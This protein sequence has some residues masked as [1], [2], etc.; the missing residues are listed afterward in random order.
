MVTHWNVK[1]NVKLVLWTLVGLASCSCRTLTIA[2]NS[3]RAAFCGAGCS[4]V[5]STPAFCGQSTPSMRRHMYASV[6]WNQNRGFLGSRKSS[7]SSGTEIQMSASSDTKDMKDVGES[8]SESKS[9]SKSKSTPITLLAGF[10]GAGKTST[11][12]HLLENKEGVRIG[13]I[14]NDVASVNI[15]NKLIASFGETVELQNGC[16]CCSLAGELID[17]VQQ[18]TE[19]G[20][21][22]LDAI[23]IELSGVADPVA[24]K[25]NWKQATQVRTFFCILFLCTIYNI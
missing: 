23:V 17:S 24:V 3:N 10:L 18:V 20:T 16:A 25:E 9:K 11:L 6:G 8:E 1:M 21:R 2:L 19:N 12:K 15:D 13:V 7:K 5:K 4:I 14:V 22:D